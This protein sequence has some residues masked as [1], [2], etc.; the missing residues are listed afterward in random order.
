MPSSSL[1]PVNRSELV[2]DSLTATAD[3]LDPGTADYGFEDNS[4]LLSVFQEL[5]EFTGENATTGFVVPVLAQNFTVASNDENYTFTIRPNV[6]FSNGH[7]MNASI[8]WFS[9]VRNLYMGQAIELSNFEYVTENQT[10][11]SVTGLSV[12][13]G[14][15]NAVQ[16]V[17]GLPTTTN[18]TLAQVVLNNMLS[19]FD[20]NNATI[21]KIMAYPH[22]AYVVTGPMTFLANELQSYPYFLTDI[23]QW[24]ADIVDPAYVDANGGVQANAVNPYFSENCGPGTGPY[25]VASVQIGFTT[26]VLKANPTYWALKATNYPVIAQPPHI[27]VIIINEGLSSNSRQEAFATNQAQI[28][29]VDFTLLGQLWNAYKYKQ[30][31]TFDQIFDNFGEGPNTEMFAMNTQKFPTDNLDFRLAVVHAINYTQLLDESYTFNG[32]VYGQTFL[33]PL[34]PEWGVYYNPDNLSLYSYNVPLAIN[35]LNQAGLQENFSVILPNG[36]TIGNPSA[37]ALGPMQLEYIAPAT[38][39]EETQLTILESDLGLIGLPTAAQGGT[40]AEFLTFTTPQD[41]PV[42]WNYNGWGPDWNDPI[43]QEI[44]DVLTPIVVNT[45]MNLTSVNQ[46]INSLAYS[47]NQTARIQGIAQIYNITYNYAPIIWLPN[48]EN[49]ILKQP[50]VQGLI[51]SPYTTEFGQYWYNTIYYS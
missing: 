30:Y 5:V 34:T 49:Y 17:T 13:W 40:S 31:T 22:Q 43:L 16:N 3:A 14:L 21:Q 45:W 44:I 27:P 24:W 11:P 25:Y 32:T 42:F 51:Y 15:L 1:G 10:T 36:T 50:Y 18:Y 37:P 8:V 2:D 38:P 39:V 35:Y 48:F 47:T 23:A 12:P 9:F 4:V 26:I 7:A 28:S 20:A 41:T 19:N 29:S 6:T 33:G 46:I